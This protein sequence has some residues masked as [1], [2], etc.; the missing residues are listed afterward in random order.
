MLVITAG[1]CPAPRLSLGDRGVHAGGI[2]SLGQ[3]EPYRGTP[4][5]VKGSLCSACGRPLP[6]LRNPW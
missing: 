4:R 5:S 6:L 1:R 2:P 3:A